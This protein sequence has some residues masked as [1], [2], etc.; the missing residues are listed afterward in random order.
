VSVINVI[1]LV[2]Y[3]LLT[4]LKTKGLNVLALVFVS[5]AVISLAIEAIISL[6]FTGEIA[7]GWS[8]IVA[9]CLLPVTAAIL[10]IYF[11]TKNSADLQKIFHT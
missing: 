3:F 1:G 9:A 8:A 6:Y 10:F 11:R 5:V 2:L 4:R 7:L